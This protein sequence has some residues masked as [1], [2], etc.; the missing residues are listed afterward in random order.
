M[1]TIIFRYWG[2][3]RQS[4]GSYHLLVYHSLDVAAVAAKWWKASPAIRRGLVRSDNLAEETRLA[5]TLFFV[6]LHDYGKYDVRFQLR[7]KPIWRS[8][9]PDAGSYRNLPSEADCR[10]YFHGNGGLYWIEPDHREILAFSPGHSDGGLSFLDNPDIEPSAR[11][12]AWKPWLEAVTGHHGHIRKTE[13]VVNSSLPP[14]SDRRLADVDRQARLEWLWELEHFFLHPAD[15]SLN[16]TPP[17][18][19]PLLAGFCSIADWLASR[20]DAENFT[21]CHQP[22]DLKTYFEARREGDA[23]RILELAGVI[24]HPR[25]YAGVT[26]LLDPKNVP[27]S[28]QT[29]VDD[30]PLEPGLTLVEAPTGCGKTEAALAYAWRLVAA[31]L[32]DSVVFALPTQAT[33]N[34]ML[35]RLER[36]APLLFGNRP[37]VLLAHGRSLFKDT[38]ANLKKAAT[39][40][41]SE[42]EGWAQCSAWLAESRKRVFLGQVGVCTVDQVLISV[43][44]VKHR[45]IRGFGV[46][47]SVLIVDEVHAYDA[48]MYGLLEEV[49]RQQRAAGGSAI[50]LSATLSAALRKQLLNAWGDNHDPTDE[51]VPYPLVTW[52]AGVNPV[53]LCLDKERQPSAFPVR[54]ELVATSDMLPDDV[55]M[56]RIVAA[57]EAG[58]QVAVVCNLVD[59]AQRLTRRLRTRTELPVDLFHARFCFMHRQ[60]KE[61]DAKER[62]GPIGSR[63]KGRIL[64]ATQVIEQ[65][66]DLDF[67]WLITQL[68]P[69]DLLF[70][71]MG[72]MH[73]HNRPNRP[74]GFEQPFCTVLIPEGHAYGLHGRI[75]ADTRVLWRTARM[76]R[77]APKGQVIFPGAYR[78]WIESVYQEKSW[79]AEPAEVEEIHDEFLTKFEASRFSALQMVHSAMNPLPDSDQA[80]TAVTRDGDMNLTLLPYCHTPEGKKLMDGII[81]DSLDDSRKPEVLTL[82]SIGVPRSWRGMLHEPD[83]EGRYWLEMRQDGESLTAS[84]NGVIFRYH[85]D[86]GM[87]RSK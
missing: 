34:A 5:W 79:G 81:L 69:V 10:G 40:G 27:R 71:R 18:C 59:D 23:S 30:V 13:D 39:T 87:E 35:D 67:D 14:T 48:Y 82:N 6:A 64:V 56:G 65:S 31:G 41:H 84:A 75:Y 54:V 33:A 47:R 1:D 29:L 73:R 44:P 85:K 12:E 45:F 7:A 62:F 72:R 17:P 86:M 2:K 38:F 66:L 16:D 50:L 74:Q 4:D 15:L 46:G 42:E 43:L 24:G 68:C 22:K 49:V 58:A 51:M 3:A 80:V 9:Y 76:L 63:D 36:F 8:I 32:A 77:D 55:L 20:C 25:P 57:A 78:T 19:S 37:N 53:A 11:W 21:F 61:Q 60:E 83:N 28:V 52:T 26:A 70:Q